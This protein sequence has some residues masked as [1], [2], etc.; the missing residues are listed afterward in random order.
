MIRLELFKLQPGFELNGKADA[1]EALDSLL[2]LIHSW[3]A[4]SPSTRKSLFDCIK[5]DC[6]NCCI[7][8][9]F[10]LNLR[11][12]QAQQDQN[13]FAVTLNTEELLQNESLSFLHNTIQNE[14][15][16]ITFNMQWLQTSSNNVLQVVLGLPA[17][18]QLR[19]LFTT[20]STMNYYL[21][22][23]ICYMGAH[24]L[25]MFCDKEQW[26]IYDDMKITKVDFGQIA[27]YFVT[28]S[29]YPTILF[30]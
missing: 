6:N 7:H 2:G 11:Q 5:S 4:T 23:M 19:Q 15:K 13:L 18:F 27:D 21:K 16:V 28:Y 24:Y 12:Q 29:C 22:G 30:Y 8:S 9:H 3:Y 17:Q 10:F 20:N 26:T 1:F 14:P 25:C